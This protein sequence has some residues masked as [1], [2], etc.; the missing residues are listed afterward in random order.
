MVVVVEAA[1]IGI[2]TTATSSMA[3]VITTG[4]AASTT[5]RKVDRETIS[6]VLYVQPDEPPK[7]GASN[8]PR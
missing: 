3:A 7:K 6:S 5:I 8:I 2:V 4:V 1:T